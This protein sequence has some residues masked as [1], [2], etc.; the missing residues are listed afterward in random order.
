MVSELR[1][2]VR[3]PRRL[4]IVSADRS[5]VVQDVEA[6]VRPDVD[7]IH[8]E[9]I[10]AVKDDAVGR[11]V[12][13]GSPVISRRQVGVIVGLRRRA[14]RKRKATGGYENPE[15]STCERFAVRLP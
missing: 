10:S 8:R 2:V 11:G 9:W 12:V 14:A 6:A 5:A 4:Q 1:R 3:H 7:G 15:I 13:N